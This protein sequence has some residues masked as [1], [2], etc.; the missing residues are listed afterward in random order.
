VIK[1]L[2]SSTGNEG[3]IPGHQSMHHAENPTCGSAALRAPVTPA[4]HHRGNTR[5][6]GRYVRLLPT[7]FFLPSVRLATFEHGVNNTSDP[8]H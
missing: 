7:T 6:S 3:I 2:S 1:S 4:F 8:G 5:Q